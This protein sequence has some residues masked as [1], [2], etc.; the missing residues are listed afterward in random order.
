M[1]IADSTTTTAATTTTTTTTIAV[2]TTATLPPIAAPTSSIV[3]DE[4]TY[5]QRFMG[6][7]DTTLRSELIDLLGTSEHIESVDI[8]DFDPQ[9]DQIIIEVTSRWS[10]AERQED[11]AWE[12]VKAMSQLWEEGILHQ[13]TWTPSL[14]FV[15]SQRIYMCNAEFMV[16]LADVLA[17]RGDWVA[18]CRTNSAPTAATVQST[19]PPGPDPVQVAQMEAEITQQRQRVTDWQGYVDALHRD[20]DVLVPDYERRIAEAVSYGAT[21]G[22]AALRAEL[23]ELLALVSEAEQQLVNEQQILTDLESRYSLLLGS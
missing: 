15:N 23:A 11:G 19:N 17:G 7:W 6:G 16:R 21:K 14:R 20:R 10:G 5:R 8:V 1:T 18:E 9:T 22:E 4:A 13:P 3:A 2:L 12:V